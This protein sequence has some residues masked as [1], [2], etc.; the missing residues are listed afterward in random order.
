MKRI[1]A[2]HYCIIPKSNNNAG[3]NLLY[4]LVRKL[5]NHYLHD[6]EIEWELRSQWDVSSAGEINNSNID[7]ILFGGGGLFLPDQAGAKDNNNTGWQ[8]NIPAKEYKEINPNIYLAAIGFN[9]FRKSKVSKFLIKETAKCLFETCKFAGIRNYG[10]IKELNSITKIKGKLKWLPCPTT[11]INTML[12]NNIDLGFKEKTNKLILKKNYISDKKNKTLAIN[13]S[14]DRLEQRNIMTSDFIKLRLLLR[15]LNRKGFEIVYLAHKDLDLLAYE[16]IGSQFFSKVVNI[17]SSSIDKI[18]ENYL[19]FDCVMGG[20]G[21]S[22]MIPFGLGIPIISITSHDKQKYFMQDAKL[23]F[24]DIELA[25][26]SEVEIDKMGKDQIKELSRQN[27]YN[28]SYQSKGINA[29]SDFVNVI[30]EIEDL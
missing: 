5:I 21:H 28:N 24:F 23:D 1:K 6:Y 4:T 14:C 9:W 2:L 18:I 30:R 27:K 17:S 11:I 7:F 13:L 20:R 8:I 3:D 16:K 22:L 10:S 19:D 25:D 12:E 26:L 15:N 29:W